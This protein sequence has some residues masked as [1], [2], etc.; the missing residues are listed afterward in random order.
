MTVI[1]IMVVIANVGMDA[2]SHLLSVYYLIWS[3]QPVYRVGRV[4]R[5]GMCFSSVLVTYPKWHLLNTSGT[6][7]SSL[8]SPVE[9]SL[10][11]AS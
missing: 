10:Y 7:P 2:F 3:L 8:S 4:D 6:E 11:M 5:M 9:F 1:A